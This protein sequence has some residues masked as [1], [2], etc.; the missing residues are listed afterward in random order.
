MNRRR[1]ADQ[2]DNRYS[3]VETFSFIYGYRYTITDNLTGLDRMF[4]VKG[5]GSEIVPL[6]NLLNTIEENQCA[7][8]VRLRQC[9]D[10]LRDVHEALGVEC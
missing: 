4:N 3:A 1:Q 10:M 5:N 2:I 8:E 6:V 7:T 9:Q